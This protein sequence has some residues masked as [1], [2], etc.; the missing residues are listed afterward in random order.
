MTWITVES[1]PTYFTGK[2]T[3]GNGRVIAQA[4]SNNPW[5]CAWEVARLAL[6]W[7]RSKA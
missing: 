3:A 6:A 4:D 2:A 1:R 5:W 7:V